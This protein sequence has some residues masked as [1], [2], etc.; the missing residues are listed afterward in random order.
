MV[1]H[2]TFF[3][4]RVGQRRLGT[5]KY[6]KHHTTTPTQRQQR[7]QKQQQQMKQQQMEQQMQQVFQYT[8]P[9]AAIAVEAQRDNQMHKQQ[10]GNTPSKTTTKSMNQY[11]PKQTK[12]TSIQKKKGINSNSQ[13]LPDQ[14]P[15]WWRRRCPGSPSLSRCLEPQQIA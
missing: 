3:L 5:P 10:N 12:T 15:L 4:L 14:T 2:G 6:D 7:Q 11:K 9:A 1:Y 8:V 13:F